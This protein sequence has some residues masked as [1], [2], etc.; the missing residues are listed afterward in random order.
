[1]RGSVSLTLGRTT[2]TYETNGRSHF[3]AFE[4]CLWERLN[5]RKDEMRWSEMIGVAGNGVALS[6]FYL[7]SLLTGG[8][9]RTT[10]GIDFLINFC[11]PEKK[12][13]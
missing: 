3:V 10:L 5:P 13:K 11:K 12:E 6:Y 9:N 4:R 7:R 1:M 2:N 8:N